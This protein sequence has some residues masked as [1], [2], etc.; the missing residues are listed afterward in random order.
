MPLIR[1]SLAFS[2]S[3]GRGGPSDRMTQTFTPEGSEPQLKDLMP[4]PL[5]EWLLGEMG[6]PV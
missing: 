4:H 6:L 3:A 1:R 5:S 2:I